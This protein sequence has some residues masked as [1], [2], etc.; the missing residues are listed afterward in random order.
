MKF[1]YVRY[2]KTPRPIIPI[3]LKHGANEIGYN[4]LID[5]G[6]DLCLFDAEIGSLLGIEVEKGAAKEVFGVGG[7]ASLYY[8]HTIT[9]LVGGWP[10]TIEAGFMP[11]VGGRVIPYG[12]VGQRGFFE[13]FTVKFDY[14]KEEI[15]MKEIAKKKS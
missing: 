8:L 7:K 14:S 11:S 1:P 2:G 6:A 5:S 12:L 9:I 15:E 10:F 4:V 13:M 3:I